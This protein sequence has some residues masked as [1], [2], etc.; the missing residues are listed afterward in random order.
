MYAQINTA[1]DPQIEGHSHLGTARA[2][3]FWTIS[4]SATATPRLVFRDPFK[5]C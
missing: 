2:A 4:G 1:S 3:A 5:A